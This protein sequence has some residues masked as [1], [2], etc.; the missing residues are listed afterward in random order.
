MI[1]EKQMGQL[2]FVTDPDFGLAS[3]VP[4]CF[5]CLELQQPLLL[6]LLL[7]FSFFSFFFP[8][9]LNMSFGY[10]RDHGCTEQPDAATTVP[11]MVL[12]YA[13]CPKQDRASFEQHYYLVC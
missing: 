3:Q 4:I 11:P 10:H 5:L 6:L 8:L 7:K 2:S 12:L 1:E 9:F 13:P